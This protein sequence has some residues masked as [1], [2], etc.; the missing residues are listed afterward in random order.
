MCVYFH[1][2][3]TWHHWMRSWKE[4]HTQ[5]FTSYRFLC[6]VFRSNILRFI[7]AVYLYFHYLYCCYELAENCRLYILSL[8]LADNF[9][10]SW[11]EHR[12]HLKSQCW[13]I[14]GRCL[15]SC[16]KNGSG[17]SLMAQWLRI[18]LPVQGTWVQSL[19]WENP[20]C[21]GANKPV[22]HN[23]WACALVPASHNYWAHAPQLL[24]PAHSRAHM[25][26]L[27]KP[28]CLE[29][30]LCNRRSHGHE[31]PMHLKEE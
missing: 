26:Q 7:Q 20:T 3:N 23:Y 30:M 27:L 15:W 13:F 11:V 12:S 5:G 1:G 17:T 10:K 21:S 9:H 14:G 29:P 25:L 24:K 28:A 19:V 2:I 16:I 22:H 31:K 6:T 8:V 18:R 4:M